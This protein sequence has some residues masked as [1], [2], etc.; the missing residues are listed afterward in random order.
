MRQ[1]AATTAFEQPFG[2]DELVLVDLRTPAEFAQGHPDGAINL[3]FSEKGL[4]D[5]L[6]IVLEPG[7]RITLVSSESL[8]TS[9][10]LGQLRERYR[11]ACVMDS[12][13]REAGV[14][15]KSLPDISIKALAESSP[16]GDLTIVDVREPVEWETGYAPGAVLVSLGRLRERLG[17]IPDQGPVGVICEAGVRSSTGASL[18]QAAGFTNVMTISEG[19]SGYRR[20]GLRLEFAECQDES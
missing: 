14:P 9:T 5:R 4:A 13:W 19:M 1:L 12:N 7:T 6:A 20:A 16:G 10:A 15:V 11:V 8:I 18:L 2:P 17:A 3:P